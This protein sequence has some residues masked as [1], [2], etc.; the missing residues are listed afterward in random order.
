MDNVGR[1]ICGVGNKEVNS[2]YYCYHLY[3]NINYNKVYD[4]KTTTTFK[5]LTLSI[6]KIFLLDNIKLLKRQKRSFA[7]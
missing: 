4:G 3:N 5:Q 2:N 6:H 1:L 7:A